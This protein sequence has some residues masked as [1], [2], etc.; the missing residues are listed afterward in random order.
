MGE[1]S[2][3]QG[4][5]STTEATDRKAAGAT[6]S[7]T[8]D[9]ATDI[10]AAKRRLCEL[11]RLLFCRKESLN[12][13]Y[14]RNAEA[15]D[16]A[17]DLY[18]KSVL[19]LDALAKEYVDFEVTMANVAHEQ[20]ADDA[21]QNATLEVA[22]ER[23][24]TLKHKVVCRMTWT[25]RVTC[26]PQQPRNLLIAGLHRKPQAPNFAT[27]SGKSAMAEQSMMGSVWP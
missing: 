12:A 3:S 16:K 10:E 20:E 5:T 17:Y 19:A 9:A 26:S 11:H 6:G 22:E 27:P 15:N 2:R 25:A 7:S 21:L 23:E 18:Q 13:T 4:Q 1:Q 8:G 24:R 14:R